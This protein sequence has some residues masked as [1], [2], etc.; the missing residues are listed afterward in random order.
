MLIDL[1]SKFA[2]RNLHEPLMLFRV[3]AWSVGLTYV[4]NDS[5]GQSTS[6]FLALAY[7]VFVINGV[8]LLAIF[9]RPRLGVR[10]LLVIM[11]FLLVAIV[12]YLMRREM[13]EIYVTVQIF[14]SIILVVNAIALILLLHAIKDGTMAFL[15]TAMLAADL[16]NTFSYFYPPFL[17]VDFLYFLNVSSGEQHVLNIADCVVY[18]AEAGIILRLVHIAKDLFSTRKKEQGH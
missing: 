2:A 3:H 16:G 12:Y 1:F 17:P 13:A 18:F 8:V 6:L 15:L 4:V 5:R 14:Q 9:R 7:L 11:L 10:V